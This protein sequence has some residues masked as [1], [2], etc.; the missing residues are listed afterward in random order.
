MNLL[1][2]ASDTKYLWLHI[3]QT[4][5]EGLSGPVY[6]STPEPVPHHT[7]PQPPAS[8]TVHSCSAPSSK[9]RGDGNQ[10]NLFTVGTAIFS[11]IL[12]VLF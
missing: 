12:W 4:V 1:G 6:G 3:P 5:Q 7:P 8:P 11:L 10:E 9:L 2:P